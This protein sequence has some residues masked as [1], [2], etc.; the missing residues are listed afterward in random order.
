[1]TNRMLPDCIDELTISVRAFAEPKAPAKAK[2]R[3]RAYRGSARPAVRASPWTVIFDTETTTDPSQ[4]LRFGTYQVRDG[5]KPHEAGIFCDRAAVT[6]H[7]FDT[8]TTYAKNHGLALLDRET[9]VNMVLY[10][11]GY[12]LRGTIVGFNLPFDVS[13]IAIKHAPARTDMRG[14]FSF[15]L[16]SDKRNPA[17]QI[18][19]LSQE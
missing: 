13:R 18:K 11:Y 5:N 2:L 17:I 4:A 16:S 6:K 19:H 8:I 7:E 10:R 14:G 1:M 9:F 15:T 3:R 12:E